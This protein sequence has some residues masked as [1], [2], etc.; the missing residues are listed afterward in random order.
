MFLGSLWG[1]AA[2]AVLATGV[3]LVLILQ[4]GDWARDSTPDRHYFST[5]ITST[6][7]HQDPMQYTVLS[8]R[9]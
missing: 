1:A 5:Y 9:E 2:S 4:V 8:F 3:S 7:L 6:D